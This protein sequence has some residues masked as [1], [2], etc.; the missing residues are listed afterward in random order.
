MEGLRVCIH[1]KNYI[2][3]EENKGVRDNKAVLPMKM[4][5]LF[6]STKS[7]QSTKSPAKRRR[8][9]DVSL[10]KDGHH[11]FRLDILLDNLPV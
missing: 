11:Y 8:L 2:H 9:N 4:D 10:G 1:N 5:S 3:S 7:R 6:L